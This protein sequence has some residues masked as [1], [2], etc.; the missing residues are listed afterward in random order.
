MKNIKKKLMVILAIG[1][2]LSI[3]TPVFAS[4]TGEQEESTNQTVSPSEETTNTS[5]LE[6]PNTKKEILKES[7]G[8]VVGKKGLSFEI[9]DIPV[10]KDF[11]T[12]SNSNNNP[13]LTFKSGQP[14]TNSAGNYSTVIHVI[15]DDNTS[16]DI[17]VSYI[18]KPVAPIVTLKPQTPII[19]QG[20]KPTPNLFATPTAND[21]KLNFKSGLP[22]TKKT[23]TFKT[24]IVATKDGIRKELVVS[25]KVTDQEP[26]KITVKPDYVFTIKGEII[27]PYTFVNA[28]DNSGKVTLTFKPGYEPTYSRLGMHTF[29]VIATDP[30][31][32]T[33][34]FSSYY[35]IINDKPTFKTPK[36]DLN[37]SNNSILHGITTPYVGVNAEDMDGNLL[38]WSS[39]NGASGH[40]TLNFK[41]PLKPGDI[42]A[43]SACTEVEYSEKSY[44]IYDPET[45]K[46]RELQKNNAEAKKS[47]NV[48]TN[49]VKNNNKD[50]SN[51]TKDVLPKTGD[52]SSNP[53]T[54]V[55][56][57]IAGS[58]VLVLRK[59]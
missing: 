35:V 42:F 21:V 19:A 22:S 14:I 2:V 43:L 44:Y 59:K 10:A 15:F 53:L 8:T 50:L 46:I 57:I 11:V 4:E 58:S 36:L 48:K 39:E 32:N 52:T 55:G 37:K 54:F 47:T 49:I 20:S 51:F 18:V 33:S 56:L 7:A 31:G 3:S 9:G 40:F 13:K 23:G 41:T 16:T 1:L 25:F 28:T 38:G 17:N 26:P 5:K 12:I 30:S 29:A 6:E 45:L 27:T 24:T 34:E